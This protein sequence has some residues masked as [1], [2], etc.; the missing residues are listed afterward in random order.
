VGDPCSFIYSNQAHVLYRDAAGKIWD[1]YYD[2]TGHWLLQQ[3]NLSGLTS[4]PVAVDDPSSFTYSNQAH[5]LYR[6]AAGKMSDS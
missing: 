4:G 5:V 2:G 1:S 3:I 6:D